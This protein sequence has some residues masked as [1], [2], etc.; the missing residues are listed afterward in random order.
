MHPDKVSP[1][2]LNTLFM[3]HD[4]LVDPIR[5]ELKL[6][7]QDIKF[8]LCDNSKIFNHLLCHDECNQQAHVFYNNGLTARPFQERGPNA[9]QGFLSHT[10]TGIGSRDGVQAKASVG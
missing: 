6:T 3:C 8:P 10:K 4:T 2:Q 5:M 9:E 7:T 1:Q